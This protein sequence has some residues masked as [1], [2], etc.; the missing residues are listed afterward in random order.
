MESLTRNQLNFSSY[1]TSYAVR[2]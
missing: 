1:I 2:V